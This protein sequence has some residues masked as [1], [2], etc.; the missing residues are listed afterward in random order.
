M[1]LKQFI[2]GTVA[3]V[4]LVASGVAANAATVVVQ[5]GHKVFIERR[6]PIVRVA[7]R[8]IERNRVIEIVRARKIRYVGVP[9]MYRGYYVMRCYDRFGRFGYCRI[10]PLTG[11]FLGVS[12]RL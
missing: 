4:A 5:K 12:I 6:A 10:N 2:T 9:Y 8:Y 7:P 11:A 1:K 3:A